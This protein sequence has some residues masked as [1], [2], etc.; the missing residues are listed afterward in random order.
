[1]ED[2][3][4]G[5]RRRPVGGVHDVTVFETEAPRVL[6][7]R[8]SCGEFTMTF[9]G[10]AHAAEITALHLWSVGAVDLRTFS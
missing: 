5:L 4:R 9:W 1:V 3:L 2:R 7:I 8:C 6:E 10:E